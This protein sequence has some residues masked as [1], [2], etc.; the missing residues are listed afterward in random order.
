M[1]SEDSRRTFCVSL[2]V[3][4]WGGRLSWGGR[5]A[6][7]TDATHVFRRC[8]SMRYDD[9]VA[10]EAQQMPL[11]PRPPSVGQRGSLSPF[12]P[13]AVVPPP[14]PLMLDVVALGQQAQA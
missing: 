2:A 10:G 6:I 4:G 3:G 5:A 9:V 12:T 11:T 8:S 14:L 13:S 1:Q 7:T